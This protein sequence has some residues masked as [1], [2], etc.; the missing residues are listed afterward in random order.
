M[1]DTLVANRRPGNAKSMLSAPPRSSETPATVD[2][3]ATAARH[4]RGEVC[5]SESTNVSAP[6][7]S[8][9][10]AVYNGAH[11]VARSVQS[12][13]D[14]HFDD[15]ELIV[16]N[17]G[18]TDA[19]AETLAGFDDPRLRVVNQTHRGLTAS[20][21]VAYALARGALLARQDAGDVSAPDRL[22]RQVALLDAQ[23]RVGLVSTWAVMCLPDGRPFQT[24]R[25]PV[26]NAAIQARL[27]VENCV[28]GAA[29]VFRRAAVEAVGPYRESFR[30]AQDY[31]LH[32]RIAEAFELANIPEVLYKCE[33]PLDA[34]IS[35]A[36]VAEQ[37]VYARVA[38]ELA[39]RRRAGG[40]VPDDDEVAALCR[41]RV[42]QLCEADRRR[43]QVRS[44]DRWA[45]SLWA[46][47]FRGP[48]L[49]LFARCLQRTAAHPSAWAAT[50]RSVGGFACLLA[51]RK[52]KHLAGQPS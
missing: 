4:A 20:L 49:A 48:S 23:P 16:V 5:K 3:A 50:A 10:M 39:T 26:G 18:S 21:N 2:P 19:T 36:N 7:V 47:G 42:A 14:Q 15:L 40:A 28:F 34:G 45:R 30:Y 12:I 6:R 17:D 25:R 44:L 29:A 31:D 8:V 37:E 9:L 33:A 24:E 13:L 22:A 52:I 11:K 35:L 27:T 38:R 41:E 1:I 51:R 32:L 43:Y 46:H